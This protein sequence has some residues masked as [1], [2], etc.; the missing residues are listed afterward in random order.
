MTVIRP[1]RTAD[2]DEWLRMREGLWP[3]DDHAEEV[4]AWL[5]GDRDLLPTAAVL[6]AERPDGRLGGFAETGLRDYTDACYD[7]PTA[8][9]EGIWV[10]EDLRRAGLA[11]AL[12]RAV[13]AWARDEGRTELGSDFH[14]DNAE[15]RA[16]HAKA[17]F[18]EVETLILARKE[19]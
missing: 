9:L 14:P 19:L 18:A 5:G 4:D 2:R 17:G 12:L 8:Y 13:E 1:I 6:V 16:F 15:S 3:G 11:T 7:R 10:D